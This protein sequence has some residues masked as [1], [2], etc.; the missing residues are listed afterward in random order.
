MRIILLLHTIVLIFIVFCSG[1]STYTVEVKDGVRYVH[2]HEPLWG[3]DVRVGLE[4][5]R[6]IGIQDAGK[7]H[8]KRT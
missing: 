3:D 7:A 2:N 4:F 5:V 1:E 6:Q 8:V